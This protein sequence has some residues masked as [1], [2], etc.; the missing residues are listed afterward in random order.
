MT[1]VYNTIHFRIIRERAIISGLNFLSFGIF[2]RV[3]QLK[4]LRNFKRGKR[5]GYKVRERA[6][7]GTRE[8]SRNLIDILN[9]NQYNFFR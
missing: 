8:E 5:G 4:I 6:N 2:K 1:Y 3:K 7:L 9:D